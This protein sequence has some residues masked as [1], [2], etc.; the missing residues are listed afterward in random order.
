MKGWVSIG[1]AGVISMVGGGRVRVTSKVG[2]LHVEDS[3]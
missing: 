1:V 3:P 2:V